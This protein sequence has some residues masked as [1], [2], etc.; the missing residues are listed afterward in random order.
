MHWPEQIALR[1]TSFC[2]WEHKA[3]L[4]D[5]AATSPIRLPAIGNHLFFKAKLLCRA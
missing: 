4:P 3:G 5:I 1:P 2:I